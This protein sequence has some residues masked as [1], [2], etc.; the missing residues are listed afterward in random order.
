MEYD[1]DIDDIQLLNGALWVD[2][3]EFDFLI[4]WDEKLPE[5]D[6]QDN[7]RVEYLQSSKDCTIYACVWAISDL[8]N[9]TFSTQE[10]QNYVDKSFE[11]GRNKWEWRYTQHAV[12]Y[13]CK[14][15]N[16]ANPDKKV[17]YYRINL[18][19]DA[20]KDAMKKWYTVVVTFNGNTNYVNDYMSDG[21]LN[22]TKFPNPTYSHCVTTTARLELWEDWAIYVKDNYKGRKCNNKDRNYYKL[23]DLQWLIDNWVFYLPW[24]IIVPEKSTKQTLENMKKLQNEKN[25]INEIL[26]KNSELRHCQDTKEITNKDTIHKY[27]NYLRGMLKKI[28]L[29]M[30]VI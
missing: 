6:T 3:S 20:F 23:N 16:E 7:V 10:I 22:W 2:V 26:T 12:R 4:E 11:V 9:Y 24:Y 19:S 27:S 29:E 28:E 17:I 21:V 18:M 13:V 15:W 1:K 25:I 5:L 8:F 30:K 14:R